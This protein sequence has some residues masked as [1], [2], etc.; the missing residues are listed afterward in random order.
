MTDIEIHAFEQGTRD[1]VARILT[2]FSEQ[3]QGAELTVKPSFR[4]EFKE[5]R[6]NAELR[7]SFYRDDDLADALEGF[8]VRNGV[9]VVSLLE[10]ESWLRDGIK[11]VL[12][13]P[14]LHG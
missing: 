13:R 7:V 5:G 14:A 3:L 2:E 9:P 10:L 4:K 11:D 8:I 6:L 12:S 1:L